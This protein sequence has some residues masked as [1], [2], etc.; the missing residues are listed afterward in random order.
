[1]FRIQ[2]NCKLQYYDD[3][4]RY[5]FT[6]PDNKWKSE[7]LVYELVKQL[8]PNGNVWYQYRPSFLVSEKGQLS[9]DVYIANLGLAI[10]YQGKQHF[11]P[12]EIFG[13]ADS[14]E[15][16]K[17]RDQIKARLSKAHGIKLVY[18]NYW[19]DLSSELIKQKIDEA[20]KS[21]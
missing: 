20:I 11:E 17:A 10:E 9:Y 16:Q 15:K 1:M 3:I 18:I 4:D 14:Y 7:Q 8:Y 6:L 13:G 19:E 21:V 12:V 5:E 2:R